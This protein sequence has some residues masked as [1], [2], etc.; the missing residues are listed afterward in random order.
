MLTAVKPVTL[1]SDERFAFYANAYN[2]WAVKLII[3]RYPD[4][5]S[6]KNIVG[7]FIQYSDGPLHDQLINNK[8]VIKVTYLDYDWS[9]NGT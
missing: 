4:I 2:A 7:F 1:S 8:S 6:L 3:S 5:R 9:L